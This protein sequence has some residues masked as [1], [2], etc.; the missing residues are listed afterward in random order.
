MKPIRALFVAAAAA[1][2][3]VHLHR[4]LEKRLDE[5][6]DFVMGELD[7]DYAAWEAADPFPGRRE[8]PLGTVSVLPCLY[9]PAEAELATAE[10]T[11]VPVPDP[12]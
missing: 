3:A 4:T 5:L 12:T 2:V 1:A 6:S 7:D 9:D 8:T 11:L 10:R